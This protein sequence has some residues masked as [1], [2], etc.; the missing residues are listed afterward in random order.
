MLLTS[1][2]EDVAF[3]KTCMRYA[4]I[5]SNLHAG[6]SAAWSGR[7][8]DTTT[9]AASREMTPSTRSWSPAVGSRRRALRKLMKNNFECN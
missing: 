3:V 5:V 8:R 1:C 2:L 6:W 4:K 9:T 7:W